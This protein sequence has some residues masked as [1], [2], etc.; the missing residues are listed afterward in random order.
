M[1]PVFV[2]G[3]VL[4]LCSTLATPAASQTVPPGHPRP[5]PRPSP[6]ARPAN[7]GLYS[8]RARRLV[9][10]YLRLRLLQAR[11]AELDRVR[12]VIERRLGVDELLRDETP[13]QRAR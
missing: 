12:A 3:A 11:E 8:P 13:P 6:T 7:L 10:T 4:V 1:N 5:A 2:R 9:Q